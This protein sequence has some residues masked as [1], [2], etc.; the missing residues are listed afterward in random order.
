MWRKTEYIVLVKMCGKSKL[1][2]CYGLKLLTVLP[3]A[4][5][6]R[7]RAKEYKEID[8]P[9]EINQMTCTP[10]ASPLETK[11]HLCLIWF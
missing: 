9:V 10:P 4:V 5:L 8:A 2:S 3:F 7:T 6:N 1:S 11:S